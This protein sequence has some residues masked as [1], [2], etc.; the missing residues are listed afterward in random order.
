[1]CLLNACGAFFDEPREV[2]RATIGAGLGIVSAESVSVDGPKKLG[3]EAG[4]H[5]ASG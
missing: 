3:E 4:I 2:Q 5:E 1:M